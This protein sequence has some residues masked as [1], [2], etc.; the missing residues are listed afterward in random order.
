MDRYKH[1][2]YRNDWV[3]DN[4]CAYMIGECHAYSRAITDIPIEPKFRDKLLRLS[5]IKGAQ[6]TTAIE[7]NTLSQ[8]E[9]DRIDQGWKL[10]PSKEYLEIEVKNILEA[11]NSL[12]R[13]IIAE[14][15]V[16]IITPDLI[17]EFHRMIGKN[18]G[19]HL[20]AVPGRFRTDERVV[21]TYLA[22]DHRLVPDMIDSL[23]WIHPFGDGNGRTGRLLEFYILLR[24][25]LPSIV[26]HILS[27]FYNETRPEYYRQLDTARKK[28]DLTGF[29]KYAVRGFRDGLKE[30][31]L[32]LPHLRN[33]FRSQVYEEECFQAQTRIDF[34]HADQPGVGRRS[35]SGT[36]ARNR[37]AVR[38]CEPTHLA[39]GPQG[40]A[41][42][43]SIG[44][45]WAQ[46]SGQYRSSESLDP[47]QKSQE[48]TVKDRPGD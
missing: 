35:D 1:I 7:G 8:E 36:D 39:T 33:F 17:M 5:L 12:L 10:P 14:G 27:N 18:L 38:Y 13:E 32:A 28:C 30:H 9:I 31:F 6:A 40:V 44:Q 43:R 41:G 26:S 16:R 29:I 19:D 15:K 2:S 25:G 21:G 46:V 37:K 47:R 11:F 45:G 22:P 4:E 20:D 42:G 24:A 34:E 48:T 3:I 23:E